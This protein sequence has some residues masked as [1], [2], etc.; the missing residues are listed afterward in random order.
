MPKPS[1]SELCRWVIWEE[2]P[3]FWFLLKISFKKKTVP[4]TTPLKE[5]LVQVSEAVERRSQSLF[6][7]LRSFLLDPVGLVQTLLGMDA[8]PVV[9]AAV[10]TVFISKYSAAQLCGGA[11]NLFPIVYL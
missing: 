7:P 10:F 1:S 4:V 2:I 6:L 9:L 5:L 8:D 11:V 3:S